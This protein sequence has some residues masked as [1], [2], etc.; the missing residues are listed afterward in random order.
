M[1]AAR[2]FATNL[3][4][5]LLRAAALCTV[6]GCSTAYA[7]FGGPSSYGGRTGDVDTYFSVGYVGGTSGTLAN[8]PNVHFDL[9]SAWMWGIGTGY[10][11]NDKWSV[12]FDF[13]FGYTTLAMNS[14]VGGLSGVYRSDA[15]YFNGRLNLEYTPMPGPIS[16][17]VSAG[18]GFN[19]FRTAVPGA[20]PQVI[21][22]PTFYYWWCGTGVPTYDTTAFSWNAGLGL[23]WDPSPGFF[24]KLMYQATWADYSSAVGTKQFNQV[25][26]QIG[27][28]VKTR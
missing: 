14:N 24:V 2:R 10:H 21:C 26:L 18:I 11:F 15:D 25:V 19:N 1:D 16:P 17:V 27:G 28:K 13:T 6:L 8:N 4:T 23:R 3:A 22:T 12:L 9:D 5:H 7:Q 20:P